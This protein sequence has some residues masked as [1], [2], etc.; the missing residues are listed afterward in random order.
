MPGGTKGYLWING[1]LL[2]RYWSAGPQRTLHV[3]WP[4]L[5]RAA[6][7]SSC[8]TSTGPSCPPWISTLPLTWAD[9][10]SPGPPPGD[11]PFEAATPPEP[12]PR[13]CYETATF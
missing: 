9:P 8:W 11:A 1:H 7:R 13:T 2:G 5:R 4:L 12:R 10:L 3:P 6:T